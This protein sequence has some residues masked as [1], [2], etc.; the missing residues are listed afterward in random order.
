[1]A[2]ESSSKPEEKKLKDDKNVDILIVGSGP[3]ACTAAIY[4]AR[5]GLAPLVLEGDLSRIGGQ[6]T[7]TH[8]VENFPG[9]PK[10]IGGLDLA[11]SF[12]DQAK[13]NGAFLETELVSKIDKKTGG[14]GGFT[15]YSE[16]PSGD[17][18]ERNARAVILATG[19]TAK[20][21]STIVGTNDDEFWN[22][23]VSAC[24]VCDGSA[25]RFRSKPLLVVGGGDTAMEEA[26][27]LSNIGSDIYVVIRRDVLRA[28]MTMQARV[29]ANEKIKLFFN[30]R[31]STV[32]GDD[33]NGVTG[34]TIVNVKT[35]E[36]KDYEIAGF[37]FAIGH[38]PNSGPV[39]HLVTLDSANYVI[40]KPGSTE[41]SVTGLFAAGDVQDSKW[42]QAITAAGTG[43]QAALQALHYVGELDF[44]LQKEKEKK[45]N[46]L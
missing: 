39:K 20:R 38:E 24:A 4:A 25:P 19:A 5:G 45:T 28:S 7:T 18:K 9:F 32:T 36:K 8:I 34:C 10:G 43:C 11:D 6:L 33:K 41:T 16:T 29:K 23:G 37:F 42:R 1:M 2:H 13:N 40:T 14:H 44:E 15:V 17:K 21:D 30:S 46:K 12:R 22:R 27:Y 26:M 31:V 35:N 3:A